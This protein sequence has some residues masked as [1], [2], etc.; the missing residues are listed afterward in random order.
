MFAVRI[1]EGMHT[2]Y[3]FVVRNIDRNGLDA[4]FIVNRCS[5]ASEKKVSLEQI[6]QHGIAL[7]SKGLQARNMLDKV[8]ERYNF[9][10]KA[11]IELNDP[12]ILLNLVR[13]SNLVT[14]LAEAVILE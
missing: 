14:V 1:L 9:N 12:D 8:L 4:S 2:S 13:Q 11:R 7:P 6:A 10:L 5:L 3:H